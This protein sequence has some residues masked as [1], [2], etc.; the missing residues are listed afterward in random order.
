MMAPGRLGSVCIVWWDAHEPLD[1][2][3]LIRAKID[4]QGQWR[5]LTEDDRWGPQL[6]AGWPRGLVPPGLL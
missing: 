6:G 5:R 1:Q 4:P 2:T 3:D